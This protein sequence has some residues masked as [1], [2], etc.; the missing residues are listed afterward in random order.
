VII[1]CKDCG[2][3]Y[4]YGRS[5]CH[6]CGD[7]TLFFG[8]IFNKERS[9]HSWNCESGAE[10]IEILAG[11]SKLHESILEKFSENYNRGMI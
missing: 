2:I 11:E 7:K 9:E 3:E 8:A 1:K 10:Y 6:V 4:T 5:I